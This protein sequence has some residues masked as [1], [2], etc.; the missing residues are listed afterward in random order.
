MQKWKQEIC[1]AVIKETESSRIFYI[2]DVAMA[3]GIKHIKRSDFDVIA[4]YLQ[5]HLPEPFVLA[6]DSN[7]RSHDS[8]FLNA[9][10]VEEGSGFLAGEELEDEDYL[11]T[12]KPDSDFDKPMTV[13][14]KDYNL[15]A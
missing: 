4:R 6:L 2:R 8:H 3:N 12:L 5:K 11:D 14:P 13:F 15:E 7:M 1:D 9:M 10:V